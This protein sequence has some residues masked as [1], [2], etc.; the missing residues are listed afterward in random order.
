MTSATAAGA[1]VRLIAAGIGELVVSADPA[2]VLVAYGL[3]S[4]V[5]LAAHDARGGIAALAHFMLPAGTASAEAPVK[6][7]EP[8]LDAFLEA[9]VAAG[10]DPARATYKAA[11]GAAMLR[12]AGGGLDI[13]QRNA[14]AVRRGLERR[15]LRLAAADLG[16]SAGRTVQLETRTG[17]FLVRSIVGTTTL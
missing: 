7:V 1:G 15:G 8:G 17:R 11:G 13:G 12:L 3:G 9:F 10:G 4:C 2:T 5:A 14:E 6:F 16:G